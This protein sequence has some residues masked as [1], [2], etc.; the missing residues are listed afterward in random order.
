MRP[1][2]ESES[3]R[4]PELELE[5]RAPFGPTPIPALLLVSVSVVHGD[6]L[7]RLRHESP[8]DT[9]R[10]SLARVASD[11]RRAL[12]LDLRER[13][14]DVAEPRMSAAGFLELAA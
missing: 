6:T 12:E 11:D 1:P 7:R 3:V 13:E 4:R 2:S 10:A 9:A 5:T 8:L 14:S